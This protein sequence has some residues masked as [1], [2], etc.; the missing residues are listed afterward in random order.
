LIFLDTWLISNGANVGIVQLIG[1]AIHKR[2]L[3]K[4]QDRAVAIGVCNYGCVK[5]I[6]DFQRLEQTEPLNDLSQSRD[7]NLVSK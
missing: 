4:P 7:E 1:Q 3:T 2:K 5:N 6:N